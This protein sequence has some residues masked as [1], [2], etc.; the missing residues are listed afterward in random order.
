MRII[1]GEKVI[2]TE[3]TERGMEQFVIRVDN[4]ALWLEHRLVKDDGEEILDD[5]ECDW[6]WV[7]D[8][9]NGTT[10]TKTLPRR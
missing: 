4:D 10:A 1:A 9:L 3:N 8:R 2:R 6:K 7:W 5:S